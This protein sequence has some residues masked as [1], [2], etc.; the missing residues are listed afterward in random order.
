MQPLGRKDVLAR[1]LRRSSEIGPFGEIGRVHNER[2]ALPAAG[3][4][5]GKP[6]DLWSG[7]GAAVHVNDANCVHEFVANHN[8]ITSLQDLKVRVIG[9]WQHRWPDMSPRDTSL[10]QRPALRAVDVRGGALCRLLMRQTALPVSCQRRQL[11]V[12]RLDEQRG[13]QVLLLGVVLSLP[14]RIVVMNVVL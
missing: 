6:L 3:R 10:G 9:R 1:V 2:L 12:T 11:P 13:S 14:D 8:L 4:V 5:A 7:M